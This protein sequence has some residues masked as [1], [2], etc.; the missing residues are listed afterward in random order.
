MKCVSANCTTH[1]LLGACAKQSSVNSVSTSINQFQLASSWLSLQSVKKSPFQ[2]TPQE[3][4]RFGCLWLRS[5]IRAQNNL[6][7]PEQHLCLFKLNLCFALYQSSSS[8]LHCKLKLTK[9]RW[10]CVWTRQDFS[11]QL[12]GRDLLFAFSS[13]VMGKEGLSQGRLYGGVVQFTVGSLSGARL[14]GTEAICWLSLSA[15]T[16]VP[17]IKDADFL[18]LAVW[19][20]R[21]DIHSQLS[22]ISVL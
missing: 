9:S 5:R 8:N 20:M 3:K 17:A 16:T 10:T 22:S 1:N 11:S 15:T 12:T 2:V 18:C 7:E 21:V 14:A 19:W 4:W 6:S 13:H